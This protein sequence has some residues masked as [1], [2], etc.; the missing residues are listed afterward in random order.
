MRKRRSEVSL[1]YGST[2]H[3]DSVVSSVAPLRMVGSPAR[4]GSQEEIW[5]NGGVIILS[6][7]ELEDDGGEGK[8]V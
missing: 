5:A 1:L 8:S 4:P 7:V 3:V 2:S 6:V